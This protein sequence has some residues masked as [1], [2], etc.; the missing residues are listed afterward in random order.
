MSF[1]RYD[2]IRRP[3]ESVY[4]VYLFF[5]MYLVFVKSMNLIRLSRG[6]DMEKERNGE[7]GDSEWEEEAEA[8]EKIEIENQLNWVLIINK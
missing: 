5:N 1:I 7:A 6:I 3:F 2:F 4:I 8:K